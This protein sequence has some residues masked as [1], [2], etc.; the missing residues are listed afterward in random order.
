M[1][2]YYFCLENQELVQSTST[3]SNMWNNGVKNPG[4]NTWLQLLGEFQDENIRNM[5]WPVQSA[6]RVMARHR[7]AQE[8]KVLKA[9]PFVS[10]II[11]LTN[12]V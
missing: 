12:T 11:F 6:E 4:Q 3:G 1:V 10:I 7:T 2:I 8:I 9:L 5:E